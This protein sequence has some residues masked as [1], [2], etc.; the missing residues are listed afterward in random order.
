MTLDPVKIDKSAGLHYNP[1]LSDEGVPL[2][3]HLLK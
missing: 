2:L 1:I 3:N